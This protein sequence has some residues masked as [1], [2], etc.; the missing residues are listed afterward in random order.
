MAALVAEYIKQND[1]AEKTGLAVRTLAQSLL[2]S[3]A[4]PIVEKQG[5][6]EQGRHWRVTTLFCSRVQALQISARL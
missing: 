5:V 3:T 4:Q 6:D 1:L 2:M